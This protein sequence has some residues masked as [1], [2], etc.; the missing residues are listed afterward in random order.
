MWRQWGIG[1]SFRDLLVSI[2]GICE[3]KNELLK[4]FASIRCL[5]SSCFLAISGRHS[6]IS[7]IATRLEQNISFAS[8]PCLKPLTRLLSLVA[9]RTRSSNFSEKR[10][11]LLQAVVLQAVTCEEN[12]DCITHIFTQSIFERR[13][14]RW[15]EIFR[16]NF[17]VKKGYLNNLNLTQVRKKSDEFGFPSWA[18]PFDPTSP[19]TPKKTT[20]TQNTK[21]MHGI[22]LPLLHPLTH[23]PSP[24]PFSA[25][26]HLSPT[27]D[28]R[29]W[30]ALRRRDLDEMITPRPLVN[31]GA[32]CGWGRRES[33]GRKRFSSGF[34]G[35]FGDLGVGFHDGSWKTVI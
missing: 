9:T 3:R 14:L 6:R 28:R 33:A 1:V 5:V 8:L 31:R 10:A 20:K 21:H 27:D 19:F 26:W 13:L 35:R 25:P 15:P 30:P 17:W 24:R 22:H 11:E 12:V 4:L 32:A 29:R 16:T 18:F 2:V 23:L 7:L 34:L